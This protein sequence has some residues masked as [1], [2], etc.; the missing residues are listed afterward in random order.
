MELQRGNTATD[1]VTRAANRPGVEVRAVTTRTILTRTSGFLRGYQ[2]SLN[3]YAGCAFGCSYCYARCFAVTQERRDRWGTWVDAKT[4]AAELLARECS[5]GRLRDGDSIYMS[6][7][8]DPY[9]PAEAR[10]G[11]T[12]SLLEVLLA[13]G[14]Q[15][16]LTIQT[17]SPLVTRDIDLLR[18][19]ERVRVSMTITTDSEA[20]RRRYE[21]RCAPIDA[22]W[23]AI[24]EVA[25]AGIRV[26]LSASP[27]L[28]LE[29]AEAFA[30][31][32]A[33]LDAST[34]S[35]QFLKPMGR[36]FASGSTDEALAQAAADGWGPDEYC[37]ARDVIQRSLAQSHSLWEG[38]RGYGPV[39]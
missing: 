24:R 27:M 15:P 36:R 2:Y 21:P 16:R 35:A 8:T 38:A 14:I 30:R 19:F 39:E 33:S 6:S 23:E 20:V 26:G 5:S 4:N 18:R 12:R 32:F 13:R 29:D 17:R 34:Y 11:I 9:Q 25:R 7:A 10:F 22:R 1:I 3:P 31:Q 37:A 28:P